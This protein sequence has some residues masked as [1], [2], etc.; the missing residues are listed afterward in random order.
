MSAPAATFI[1]ADED[2]H[3]LTVHYRTSSGELAQI[4]FSARGEPEGYELATVMLPERRRERSHV[5]IYFKIDGAESVKIHDGVSVSHHLV[6]ETP[7]EEGSLRLR[8]QLSSF[9]HTTENVVKQLMN[10][11]PHM[12]NL[13]FGEDHIAITS[14]YDTL[15]LGLTPDRYRF[16]F[17]DYSL[18]SV[19]IRGF[20]FMA[21]GFL[22]E[23]G[24]K[25]NVQFAAT[26]DDAFRMDSELRAF[27]KAH[28][29][30][31]QTVGPYRIGSEERK[32]E[33]KLTPDDQV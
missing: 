17:T 32:N 26:H 15:T 12:D 31:G 25:F 16:T 8:H 7:T 24:D 2:K 30:F 18:R 10:G 1:R 9:M 11:K 20:I 33:A 3:T 4:V 14:S 13:A 21:F 5:D 22:D 23:N 19:P 28:P 27:F 29:E 6:L